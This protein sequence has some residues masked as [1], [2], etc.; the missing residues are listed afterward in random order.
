MSIVTCPN[1]H[2]YNNEQ[3]SSCPHCKKEQKGN[4]PATEA[5]G[6]EPSQMAQRK[7]SKT[8]VYS[9]ADV[10]RVSPKNSGSTV[11]YWE[12]KNY[13]ESPVLGWLVCIEGADKGKEFRF[14]Q[15]VNSIGRGSGYKINLTDTMITRDAAVASIVYDNLNREFYF[16]KGDGLSNEL[17]YINNKPVLDPVSIK[18]YDRIKIASSTFIFIPFCGEQF[19]WEEEKP[20]D[21][22]KKTDVAEEKK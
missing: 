14:A 7:P 5:Y 6:Y 3:H 20:D 19:V 22:E 15:A 8:E 17:A 9:A 4:M 12:E 11:M 18:M 2:M 13:S 1:G 10:S 21:E 16:T